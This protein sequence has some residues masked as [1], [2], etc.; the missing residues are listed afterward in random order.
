[1]SRNLVGAARLARR[2]KH[3][4]VIGAQIRWRRNDNWVYNTDDPADHS[5]MFGVVG[6][7]YTREDLHA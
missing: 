3:I 5:E 2:H 4:R 6:L 1:M 7:S